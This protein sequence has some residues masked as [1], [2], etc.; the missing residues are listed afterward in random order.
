MNYNKHYA[1]LIERAR[2]RILEVYIEKHHIVPRCLGGTNDKE[3]I[4]ALTPEEH[5]VAHQLLVKMYPKE[6]KLVYAA[7]MM[8]V[9]SND[10]RSSNKR[11]KWL[12]EKYVSACRARVGEQNSSYGKRWYY[13]PDTLESGKFLVEDVP[14]EWQTG[15]SAPKVV[16]QKHCITCQAKIASTHAKWCDECRPNPKKGKQR[17]GKRGKKCI[18]QGVTYDAASVAA[19]ELNLA[20]QSLRW[21]LKSENFPEYYY[22]E[23]N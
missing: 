5:Y 14:A 1:I 15:R 12:R 18:I 16:P 2:S 6:H 13:N 21:R 8:T 4:V 23:D 17:P 20:H 10:R 22:L 9:S 11:Y 3:N 19:K 7:N